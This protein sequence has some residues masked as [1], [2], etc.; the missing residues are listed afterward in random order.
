MKFINKLEKKFGKYAIYDVMKYFMIIWVAV[1]LLANFVPGVN[2]LYLNYLSLDFSEIFRGQI[3]RIVTF[4]FMPY[5]LDNGLNI[6]FFIIQVSLYLYI[7]RSL[8]NVWGAF[9]FNLFLISGILFNVVGG[10]IYYLGVWLFF[11]YETASWAGI[12]LVGVEYL[13][14]S[15]F[16]AFA[17]LFSDVEVLLYMIIPVKVKYLAAIDAALLL[18]TAV[19]AISRGAYYVPIGILVAMA[20]FFLFYFSFKGNRFSPKARKR[21]ASFHREVNKATNGPRHRCAVCGRTELDDENLEFRYCS[22]CKGNME[23]CQDHIFTHEHKK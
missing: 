9:R 17:V 14:Q 12:Y 23:Y 22:K 16:F 20:N 11:G 18:F 7:G 15:L 2:S 5:R 10:L 4:I 6:I 3:W 13:F 1:T 21:K 8:E 19:E